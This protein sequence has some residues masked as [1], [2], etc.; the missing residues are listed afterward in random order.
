[1]Q[2]QPSSHIR[3]HEFVTEALEWYA[4]KDDLMA[5]GKYDMKPVGQ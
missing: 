5:V 4:S 1:V 2:T 3:L